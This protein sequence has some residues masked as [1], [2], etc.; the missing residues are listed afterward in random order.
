MVDRHGTSS[1]GVGKLTGTSKGT[2]T[3][4]WKARSNELL[5]IFRTRD[6]T[7]FGAHSCWRSRALSTLHF[8]LPTLRMCGEGSACG[9][10]LLLSK[11]L[12]PGSGLGI[13]VTFPLTAVD[14]K[15][16][17]FETFELAGL[18]EV[19]FQFCDVALFTVVAAKFVEHLYKHL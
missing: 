8:S 16:G 12:P 18:I 19:V 4:A 2:V 9:L 7:S 3:K 10:F 11:R 15:I 6:L 17:L 14:F 13:A 5:T 1:A